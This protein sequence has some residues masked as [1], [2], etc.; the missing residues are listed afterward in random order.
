MALPPQPLNDDQ[1]R[2]ACALLGLGATRR[3]A[4]E[5]AD[6]RR[7]DLEAEIKRDP[8]FRLTVKQHELRPEIE[9]LRKLLEAARDP[10]QWR[11]AAWFLERLYPERYAAGK[12]RVVK[13]ADLRTFMQKLDQELAMK[14]PGPKKRQRLLQQLTR[15]KA[16]PLKKEPPSC[17]VPRAVPND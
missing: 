8:A 16:K 11:A 3:V 4:A 6:C 17:S 15:G 7:L 13:R 1:R 14:I 5:F 9:T 10:K 12:R 2:R